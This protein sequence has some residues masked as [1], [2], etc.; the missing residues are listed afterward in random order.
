MKDPYKVLRKQKKV[1]S[2]RKGNNFE[3]IIAKMFNERFKT[4]EFCRTPGSGAFATTHNL[5]EHMKVY[6]DLITPEKFNFIIECK[7]GYN[8]VGI[9]DLF[10]PGCEVWDFIKKSER[11][12]KISG[13]PSIIIWK[14]DRKEPLVI[15]KRSLIEGY[16]IEGLNLFNE[17]K[18]VLLKE[19]I[20]LYDYFWFRV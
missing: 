11:D 12:A 5:P 18:I 4:E 13:K 9:S 1:N 2:R 15:I 19:I 8:K 6:G 14:Q 3:N 10:K 16:N 7:K 20:K 17:Y